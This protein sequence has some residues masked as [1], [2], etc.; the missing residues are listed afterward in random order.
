[1]TTPTL[2]SAKIKAMSHAMKEGLFDFTTD[3]KTKVKE[4]GG[5][6][7]KMDVRE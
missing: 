4:N 1:M 5:R 3:L 6:P 2:T 7:V